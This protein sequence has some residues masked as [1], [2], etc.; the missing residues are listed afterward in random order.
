TQ[1]KPKHFSQILFKD[2]PKT[3]SP[4]NHFHNIN[5]FTFYF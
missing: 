2:I 4:S 3:T 1:V 5:W